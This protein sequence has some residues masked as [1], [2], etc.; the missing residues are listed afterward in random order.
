MG[1]CQQLLPLLPLLLLLLLLLPH[2]LLQRWRLLWWL[3]LW[4]CVVVVGTFY[5]V[6]AEHGWLRWHLKLLLCKQ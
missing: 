3:R 2:Q 6:G 4:E 5:I 1:G